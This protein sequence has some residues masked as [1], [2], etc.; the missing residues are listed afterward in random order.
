MDRRTT[1]ANGR[2]AASHLKAQVDAARFTDGV[3]RQVGASTTMIWR[4]PAPERADRQLL[5][6]DAFT[7]L[8]ERDGFAFGQSAKDGY[9]GYVMIDDLTDLIPPTHIVS[10]RSSH[11]YSASSIK[12]TVIM[13]VSFGTRLTLDGQEGG[14][15]RT[16]GGH[17]LPK[18]HVREI[19]DTFDDPVAVAEV[20]LGA[21]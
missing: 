9:C 14:L 19:A 11:L 15:V 16:R 5:F 7:V 8:E 13:P 21:P 1:P 18:V 20:F 12:S 3:V 10:A 2:V 6:G 4:D 17:Y